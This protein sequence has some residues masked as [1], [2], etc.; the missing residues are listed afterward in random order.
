[1]H[2]LD[3]RQLELCKLKR[4][5][6]S[7]DA[8]ILDFGCGDGHRVYQLL[9]NTYKNS[10][11]FDKRNYMQG[12]MFKIFRND[13]NMFNFKYADDGCLPFPDNYF[14]L[15]IS[16]YVFEHV[17]EQDQAF[18]EIHRILK[19]GGVSVH[20]MPGKWQMIEPHIWVPLGG[21]IKSYTYYYFWAWLGIRKPR[22]KGLAVGEVAKKNL[23][24]AKTALNYLSCREY[25][26][27]LSKIPFDY[28]WEELAYMKASYKPKIRKFAEIIARFPSIIRFIRAFH[29][30]VLFLQK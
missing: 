13:Q 25:E 1:M 14:D 6:I 3:I 27:M 20:V 18:R 11:G 22:H 23:K 8:Y 7:T 15:I 29:T 28:S 5:N 30:R 2:S 12:E 9:E 16:D 19:K 10:F 26:K 24:Y 17:L 4:I 21:L